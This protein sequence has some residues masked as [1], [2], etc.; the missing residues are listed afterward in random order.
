M[1]T[2]AMSK[3]EDN[4]EVTYLKDE[5]QDRLIEF[6]RT[7]PTINSKSRTIETALE[8]FLALAQKYGLDDRWW[9]KVPGLDDG[10]HARDSTIPYQARGRPHQKKP[11]SS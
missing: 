9:P 7:H 8:V 6:V 2:L 4:R 10:A 5:T 11:G 1:V 3:R